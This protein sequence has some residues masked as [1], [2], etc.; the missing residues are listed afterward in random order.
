MMP[1][2][3]TTGPLADSIQEIADRR[4]TGWLFSAARLAWLAMMLLSVGLLIAAIPVRTDQ[5]IGSVDPRSLRSIGISATAYA[6]FAVLLNVSVVVA[7]DIIA[8]II[9]WRKSDDWMALLVS[10]ALVTNGSVLPL[11]LLFPAESTSAGLLWMVNLVVFS[12]LI[13]SVTLLYVFPTAHFVPGWTWILAATWTI[14]MAFTLFS[15]DS[16][17]SLTSWSV[18]FQALA[19]LVWSGTGVFAQIFRYTNVSNPVQQQQTKWAL[20]GL[21][22]ATLG[23]VILLINVGTAGSGPAV[24]NILYQRIGDSFFAFSLLFRAAFITAF[25]IATLIFP[26]SFAIA[27]LRYR[28]WDIDVLINRTLVYGS[29]TGALVL[30]YFI[31][32]ITLQGVF[33]ILTGQGQ[34][35]IVASTLAIAA[36]FNPLRTRIQSGIDRRFYRRKYDAEQ[37][38]ESFSHAMRD[39]VDL[40]ELS[41]A[42]VSVIEDTMQPEYVSLWLKQTHPEAR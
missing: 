8:A 15:P 16:Q 10:F 25:R 28:L 6:N 4:R 13:S 41:K 18:P 33:R 40:D 17:L 2:H 42:L 11:T 22:A 36:L 12:G 3:E 26:I 1:I 31:S 9:F 27:I 39:E 21:T 23:P 19:L 5:L 30:V 35:A 32:V 7:H 14:L 20:L 29:L 37:A 34:F 24:P 38:M